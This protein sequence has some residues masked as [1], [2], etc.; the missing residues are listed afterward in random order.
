MSRENCSERVDDNFPWNS[1]YLYYSVREPF[2]SRTTG[3]ELIFGKVTNAQ[4]L[5]IIS[6][7]SE[8]GVIF[9]DGIESDFLEFNSGMEATIGVAEQK[10]ILI[11]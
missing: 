10:G 3:V 11:V 9:S 7:M 8:N 4:P 2:P 1:D 6:H 5:K